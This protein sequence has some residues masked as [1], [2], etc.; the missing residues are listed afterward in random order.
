MIGEEEGNYVENFES[1]RKGLR[2]AWKL[3]RE[4]ESSRPEEIK[5]KIKRKLRKKWRVP[6]LR[7]G[8]TSLQTVYLVVL[9]RVMKQWKPKPIFPVLI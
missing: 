3:A 4:I 2:E 5:K 7:G 8:T 6:T 1:L 9:M